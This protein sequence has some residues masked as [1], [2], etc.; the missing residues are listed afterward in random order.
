M[1]R[2][3]VEDKLMVLAF[4]MEAIVKEYTGQ[5]KPYLSVSIIN[6]HVGVGNSLED[7]PR[8]DAWHGGDE[9]PYKMEA[10]NESV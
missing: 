2:R 5:D 4:Q 10:Q 7:S 1:T 6:G 9:F 3:Q 8:I